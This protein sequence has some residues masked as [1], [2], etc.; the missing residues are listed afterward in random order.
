M[1]GIELFICT[2]AVRIP[3]L[4]WNVVCTIWDSQT[5]LSFVNLIV[6][7][8]YIIFRYIRINYKQSWEDKGIYVIVYL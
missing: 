2:V 7:I 8:Y 5:T 1:Y 4:L 3:Y 6:L